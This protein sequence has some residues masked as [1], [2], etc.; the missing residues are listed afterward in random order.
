MSRK[1]FIGGMAWYLTP[2]RYGSY[3]PVSQA[4][5][6]EVQTHLGVLER[7]V[8]D[9]AH[10]ARLALGEV[11]VDVVDDARD[12]VEGLVEEFAALVLDVVELVLG[13]LGLVA[14]LVELLLMV[15]QPRLGVVEPASSSAWSLLGGGISSLL[16]RLHVGRHLLDLG[17]EPFD[18]GQE[19]LL[20]LGAAIL[21][22]CQ[23]LRI[24]R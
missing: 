10:G 20:G 3:G 16:P 19:L 15:P 21:P 13:R 5:D 14:D 9:A 7:Q 17:L 23:H 4:P 12:V 22:R 6:A 11:L 24:E 8:R 2:C 1:R 18:L